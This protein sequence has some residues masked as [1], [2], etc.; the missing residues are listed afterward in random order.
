MSKCKHCGTEDGPFKKSQRTRDGVKTVW[1]SKTTCQ[2]C[3]NRRA[4]ESKKRRDT[5]QTCSHCT[6]QRLPG[7]TLCLECRTR[8]TAGIAMDRSQRTT[9]RLSGLCQFCGKTPAPGVKYCEECRVKSSVRNTKS[10]NELKRQAISH[11]SKGQMKC[12]CCNESGLGFLTIDH[13][14]GGGNKHRKALGRAASQ[15][16][17]WLRTN[18]YPAGYQVLCFNCN[19]ARGLFGV[20]PHKALVGPSSVLAVGDP[21]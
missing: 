10:R 11:Y 6:R 17:R 19:I 1:Y 13:E 8:R 4:V 18:G 12:A 5:D 20:C 15:F 2:R 16:Y 7:D 3:A 21:S 14:N 9:W